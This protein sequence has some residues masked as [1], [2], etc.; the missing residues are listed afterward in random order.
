[1]CDMEQQTLPIPNPGEWMTRQ[2]GAYV[3]GVDPRTVDRMVADGLLTAY[4]PVGK[5]GE[6]VPLILWREQVRE[7]VHARARSGKARA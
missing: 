2:A 3:L 5:P 4:R 7:L 6:V 1:M